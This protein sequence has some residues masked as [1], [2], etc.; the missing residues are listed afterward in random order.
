MFAQ[1]MIS[2]RLIVAIT[3][4]MT[5]FELAV[6]R[7]EGPGRNRRRGWPDLGAGYAAASR[8]ATTEASCSAD[9]ARH[10]GLQPSEHQQP[11]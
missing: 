8:A 4:V 1:A 5:G 11:G 7:E 10:T 9:A 3:S 6:E 2:T